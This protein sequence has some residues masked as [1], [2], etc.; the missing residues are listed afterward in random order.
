MPVHNCR[1]RPEVAVTRT[2]LS[3]CSILVYGLLT[4]RGDRQVR[5]RGLRQAADCR[6]GHRLRTPRRPRQVS[7]LQGN[8]RYTQDVRRPIILRSADT[9]SIELTMNGS[10]AN[11]RY[12]LQ[13]IHNSGAGTNQKVM[14]NSLCSHAYLK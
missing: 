8:Q 2:Y 6:A 5:A 4:L 14:R 7:R 9:M 3:T 11:Q 12:V 13:I 1:K 10:E